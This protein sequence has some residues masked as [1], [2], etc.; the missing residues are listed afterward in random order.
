MASNR[1]FKNGMWRDESKQQALISDSMYQT[2]KPLAMGMNFNQ[3]SGECTYFY[4]MPSRTYTML[5]SRNGN[6][7]QEATVKKG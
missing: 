2:L 3:E 6:I 4:Y 7:I 5:L 1:K